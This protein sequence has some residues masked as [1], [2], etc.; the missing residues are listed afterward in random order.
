MPI[1]ADVKALAG[2]VTRG[3][4]RLEGILGEFRDFVLA[5]QLHTVQSD[6]N[7]L[8]SN[9]TAETFPKHT[10]I[11]LI[12]NLAPDLPPVLADEVKLKRAFG[13][14]I[15]NSIDFQPEGGQ[16]T[17]KSSLADQKSV[18]NL[19]RVQFATPII[20]IDFIDHGPGLSEQDRAR[21][22]QPFYTKKSQRHG[23]WTFDCQRHH[24]GARRRDFRNW[25]RRRARPGRA[26]R[27]VAAD[28]KRQRAP[29]SIGR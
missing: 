18:A 15:E 16:L 5:T 17:V 19:T 14:L 1:G 6:I 21:V 24:R 22:F 12:L 4:Y 7:N 10:D 20:R 13:E 2:D 25:Q 28:I 26:F 23:T 11:N 27:S 3:I 29:T 9:V 8:L